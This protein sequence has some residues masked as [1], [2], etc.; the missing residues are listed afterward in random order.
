M[1]LLELALRL[2]GPA[3]QYR[4]TAVDT[5]FTGYRLPDRW[6]AKRES[7]AIVRVL[8]LGDSF[9]W[10]D[11]VHEED[12]YPFRMQFRMN[13]S[14]GWKRYRV[15]NAGRN[16]LNT[17][18]QRQLIDELGLLGAEPD[19][20]LLGFTFN[21]PEPSV[22]VDAEA[23]KAPIQRRWPPGRAER[24]LHRRSRLFQLFWDRIE[25]SDLLAERRIPFVVALWP[26][27][28]SPIDDSYPYFWQHEQVMAMLQRL[29]IDAVDLRPLYD[30]VEPRRLVVTPFTDA[31]P[32]ELAHRIAADFLADYVRRC[33]AVEVEGEERRRTWSCPEEVEVG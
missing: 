1:A 6:Q 30:G 8:V 14:D 29:G 3:P 33:L 27:F 10:G 7:P 32:N 19:L 5:L 31:H 23:M 24:E 25:I 26:A 2:V 15:L 12:A 17:V 4:D 21:D 16:G 20:V 13:L 28:D 9:T 22:R 11:G 18:D